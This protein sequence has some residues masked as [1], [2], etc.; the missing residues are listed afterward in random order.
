MTRETALQLLQQYNQEEYHLRHALTVEAVMRYFA[1]EQGYGEETDFWGLVGLLHDIDFEQYPDQH[2]V[3]A[4]RILRE[5]GADDRLIHAVTSHAWGHA[6]GLPEP[7]HPLEKLLYGADE[8]TGLVFAATL[9]RPSRS[10][11]DME[12]KSLKKKFK[13]KAFAAGCSRDV[14]QQ[15]A[16]MLGWPLDELMQKTLDA[17]R[18]SEAAVAKELAS[19]T[20]E[21]A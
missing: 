2:C 14:I 8:L 15:G 17:M 11:Q 21:N 16:D 19:L 20:G 10:T 3:A 9:M 18:Q 13:D 7:E 5:A 6:E 12:L 4:A 1:K